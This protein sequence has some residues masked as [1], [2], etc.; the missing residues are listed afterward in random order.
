MSFEFHL[1]QHTGVVCVMSR[2]LQEFL[3]SQVNVCKLNA[4]GGGGHALTL[5]ELVDFVA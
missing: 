3:K 1:L 5:P 2:R 4:Y